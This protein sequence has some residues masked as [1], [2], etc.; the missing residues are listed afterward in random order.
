MDDASI[1]EKEKIP[2]LNARIEQALQLK[3]ERDIAHKF[4]FNSHNDTIYMI[5]GFLGDGDYTAIMWSSCD[6][7]GFNSLS[8]SDIYNMS[9]KL[10]RDSR[11]YG[12][13][14][15]VDLLNKWDTKKLKEIGVSKRNRL[16]SLYAIV[17]RIIIRKGKYS[18][19]IVDYYS[20]GF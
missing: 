18:M 14:K 4:K 8:D 2:A 6:T 1:L 7:I 12:F 5:D 19:D 9:H 10:K 16:P 15:E 3:W 17:A 20:D 13:L 11:D